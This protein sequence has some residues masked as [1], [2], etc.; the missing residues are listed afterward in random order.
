MKIKIFFTQVFSILFLFLCSCDDFLDAE[1]QD[2]ISDKTFWTSEE[3]VSKFI[4]DIYSCTFPYIH[5]GSIF[6]EEAMSD[7][8]FLVWQGWYS[9]IRLVGNGT[10]DAYGSVPYNVWKYS[11][12][13]IRKCWH[14]LKNVPEMEM[15]S[16]N[17]R[18]LYL[19]ETRFILAYN[20]SRLIAFFGDVPFVNKVLTSDESKEI[21]RSDKEVIRQFIIEELD[22][23]SEV[24][25]GE[26][27][28]KG[29]VTWGAC[30]ML[31]A[32]IY[33]NQNNFEKVLETT[34][35]LL[36]QYSLNTAGT[37]P[38]YDLFS[39][40]VEDSPE[41][42]FSIIRDKSVGSI[43]TGHTG[44]EAFLLKG[45]SGGD[46]FRAIT[47]TGS[48][49]DSYPMADGRLIH[50]NGSIYDP[51][52][53]YANR[54]PRLAQSIVYPTGQI[55]YLDGTTKKIEETLY[56][57]EDDSTI[58]GQQYSATEPSPTGY[59]WNKYVDWSVYGM[60]EIKDCTN[61]IIIMR[62][63][64]VLLMHAEALAETKGIGAKNEVID[65][66]DQLRERCKGGLVHRDNYSS[67]DDLISLV[68]NERRIELANEGLRYYDILRWK[69][70]EKVT[71]IESQGLK[72]E[73]YGAF[74]RLDGLGKDDR[75]VLVD[76]VP[77][78]YV[79]TR[80]FESNK[81]YFWPIPQ[82]EC[83]LN[84]NLDQNPG[85]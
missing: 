21:S 13:H 58:A 46:A 1:P 51:K 4:T 20:Y 68:R 80:Y 55:R 10:Q 26:I 40:A 60:T 49:V 44:N 85:W 47:P 3:N 75:T 30:Q 65:L 52:N 63:A 33:L 56:D 77:R 7:N 48:L 24:L 9:N 62:Y 35:G 61:D 69:I 76:G 84:T 19:A 11:Y 27:R 29:R 54:D 81:H 37:T 23:A 18:D 78:R 25:K 41:I 53:P 38:Y 82:K 28:E 43:K 83:E 59:M 50:E 5:E 6:S 2:T 16:Q 15:I 32:R 57:P 14:V 39:G 12:S 22:K 67:K 45:M 31:K 36:G 42:I 72:G 70:A 64:D 79:E 73:L 17:K 66:I 34:T 8:S 74:M 71:V